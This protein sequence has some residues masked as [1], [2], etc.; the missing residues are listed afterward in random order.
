[1]GLFFRY[2]AYHYRIL[3]KIS[4]VT[5]TAIL[6]FHGSRSSESP[7]VRILQIPPLRT[8]IPLFDNE[9]AFPE[10]PPVLTFKFPESTSSWCQRPDGWYHGDSLPLYFDVFNDEGDF[11]RSKLDVSSGLSYLSLTPI[12]N[13]S[14]Q[15]PAP[16]QSSH[17]YRIC[18]DRP[19]VSL[20]RSR[21]VETYTSSISPH[22]TVDF[23]PSSDF[24]D[25]DRTPTVQVNITLLAKGPEFM[26][27]SFCPATGR[28]A[29]EAH[30]DVV[31]YDFL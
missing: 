6:V 2:Q 20:F 3:K 19:V 26:E 27:F 22:T 24:S 9:K 29:Y 11:I 15:L 18:E 12:A 31:I 21:T 7:S 4:H 16:Y 1:M 28:L 25:L 30:G 8:K 14:K 10:V 5:E 17:Y 13:L 23:G